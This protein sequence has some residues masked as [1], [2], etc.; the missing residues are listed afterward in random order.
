MGWRGVDVVGYAGPG[1][2]VVVVVV[3]VVMGIHGC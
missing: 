2:V 3:V 1:F